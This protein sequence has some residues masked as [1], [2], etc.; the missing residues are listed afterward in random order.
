[1]TECHSVAFFDQSTADVHSSCAV[2]S[3]L[4]ALSARARAQTADG[5]YRGAQVTLQ[6]ALRLSAHGAVVDL[7]RAVLLNELGVATKYLGDHEHASRCFHAALELSETAGH[8]LFV[9]S[10]CHNLSGLAHAQNQYADAERWAR[11]AVELRT[12]MLGSGDPEVADDNALL[13]TVLME[14]GRLDEANQLLRSVLTA[15]EATYGEDCVQVAVLLHN[16][17]A[18]S[19]RLGD[20]EG[21]EEQLKRALRIKEELFGPD[22]PEVAMTLANLAVLA[23]AIGSRAA[24]EQH[25]RRA[26]AALAA[27]VDE[28]HPTLI[29]CRSQLR[30]LSEQD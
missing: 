20:H 21:A 23:E 6:D 5:D 1:M 29:A 14:L 30:R 8:D 27:A 18:L 7:D 12:I 13:A 2:C 24:A 15:S 4:L 11:K 25:C 9:A 17:G 10:V 22:H 28:T 19:Y 3:T 26:I 16:L